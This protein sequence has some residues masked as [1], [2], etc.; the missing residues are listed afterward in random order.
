MKMD[1]QSRVHLWVVRPRQ[2]R[3]LA[4]RLSRISL[5]WCYFGTDLSRRGKVNGIFSAGK[6]ISITEE[7]NRIALDAKQPFLDWIAE[8]GSRQKDKLNWWASR[9]A[10]KSPLQTDFF[11]LVCYHK[12]F[13]SWV[14]GGRQSGTRIVVVEDPW[15]RSLLRRDFAAASGVAFLGSNADVVAD[16]AYWLARVPLAMGYVIVLYTW[17]KLITRLVLS[18]SQPFREQAR[19]KEGEILLYTWIEKSCFASSEKLNDAYM[20][21][22]E[23]ILSKNGETVKRLTWLAIRT[24]FLWKLRP[25]VKN[26]LVTT[27]YITFRDTVRCAASFFRVAGLRMLPRLEGSDHTLLFYRELLHEWGGPGFATYRLSYVA[28][29][30]L[31]RCY[32][33]RLKCLVYPFENQPWEKMLCL[34]FKK[35][36][37]A[38]RLIGYQHASVPSLLLSYF[39]GTNESRHVPLPDVI[40]TN[41]K[42]TLDQLKDGGFP[43]ENLIDGGAF[44]FEYLFN[45]KERNGLRAR[46]RTGEYRILVAFPISRLHAMSLLRDLLETYQVPFLDDKR[47]QRV[48][49]ILKFHPY[50]EWEMVAGRRE[51]L[52]PWFTVSQQPLSELM[53]NVDLFL[54]SPPTGTWR[55]AYLSGV[56]VLKYRGEFLDVDSTDTLRV[57][58]LPVCSRDTLREKTHALLTEAAVST[59]EMRRGFLGEVFSPVDENVWLKLAGNR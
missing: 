17:R 40:V 49:F 32:G 7:L 16:A 21:R 25:F 13:R 33:D 10:S 51:K 44:R 35:E 36:A 12:L 37:P 22:L 42:A 29:R 50:L 59:N 2:V 14:A 9:I 48:I 34:A 15:L 57:K 1:P 4:G 38:V 24:K 8:I 26:L 45:V 27:Q 3:R 6:L 28:F 5:E 18:G 41:G 11:L 43:T 19:H 23:E 55:E 54:Y 20:G 47:E 31:A 30:R 53:A 46:T 52:P 56:P 58:E 39:L